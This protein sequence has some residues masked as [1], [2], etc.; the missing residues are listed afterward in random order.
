MP[1]VTVVLLEGR[2]QEQKKKIATEITDALKEIFDVSGTT[3]SIRFADTPFENFAFDG[4]LCSDVSARE[5]K[6][7]YGNKLEPR[8]IVQ[9]LE[10]SAI[11]QRRKFARRVTDKV[12]EIV[13]L[14]A[15]NIQVYFHSLRNIAFAMGGVLVS[16]K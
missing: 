5:G 4:E 14:P 11:D 6:P 13:S 1:R 3:V 10:G 8:I 12:A 7:A 15:E 2:T 9:I 16:E